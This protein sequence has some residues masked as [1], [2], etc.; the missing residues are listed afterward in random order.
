MVK[1]EN[2]LPTILR[3]RAKRPLLPY[4]DLSKVLGSTLNVRQLLR[5]RA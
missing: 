1:V 4:Y 2:I 3:L 5:L